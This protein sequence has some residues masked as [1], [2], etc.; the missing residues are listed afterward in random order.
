[1]A[2]VTSNNNN[3]NNKE[4]KEIYDKENNMI[5]KIKRPTWISDETVTICQ[6]C[7]QYFSH[8]KRKVYICQ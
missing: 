5:I 7:N 4:Y 2:K 8:F 6:G 1:M 3:I